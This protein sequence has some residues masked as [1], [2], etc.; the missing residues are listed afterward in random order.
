MN[1]QDSREYY[2]SHKSEILT[3]FDT[4]AEAW[5]PFLASRYGGEFASAVLRR[6]RH[7]YEALIPETPYIGGDENLMTRHLVRSATSLML[8]KAMKAL[9]KTA[10]EVGKI[11]YDAVVVS[12]SQIPSLP[13]PELSAAY[14]AGE[15]ERA[16]RSQER[17]YSEDWVWEFVEG[18]GVEFT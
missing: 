6:T 5:R 12:V 9:G 4:H 15:K 8:Y 18:D 17:R 14:M 7:Q 16:R 13:G 10:E 2:L 3:Q 11:V 1:E